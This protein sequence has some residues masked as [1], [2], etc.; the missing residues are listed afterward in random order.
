MTNGKHRSFPNCEI[1]Q[2]ISAQVLQ[3]ACYR[4]C[5]KPVFAYVTRRG[6]V[7]V[8]EYLPTVRT[9]LL[10]LVSGRTFVSQCDL[11][12]DTASRSGAAPL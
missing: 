6:V 5:R 11:P 10:L 3:S 4:S 2:N 1:V 12:N 7:S 8:G 9:V